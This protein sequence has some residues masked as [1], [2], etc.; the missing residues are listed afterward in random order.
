MAHK[1]KYGKGATGHLCKHY[2]RAKDGKGEYITFS[3]Q[4]IDP[5]RTHMNYNLAPDRGLSQID[6]IHQRLDQVYCLN[7][8]DVNIMVDWIVTLPA[9]VPLENSREFFEHTYDFLTARYGGFEN[10]NVI[11]A[12]VHMD[13]K[14]PHIHFAFIPVVYDIEKG[15]DKVSAK[16]VISKKDLKTFHTD[17]ERFL[18]NERGF[19]CQVINEATKDGNRSIQELKRGTAQEQL[20]EIQSEVAKTLS[21]HL[22]LKNEINNMIAEKKGLE[23]EIRGLRE[24]I[25][26]ILGI[27]E[28]Y[29]GTIDR[30]E[31]VISGLDDLCALYQT[32]E[33]KTIQQTKV[34]GQLTEQSQKISDARSQQSKNNEFIAEKRKSMEHWMS[35]VKKTRTE[36]Q[37]QSKSHK[38]RD[39]ESR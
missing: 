3:N 37:D 19:P 11:S 7:R 1:E 20:T 38:T 35:E 14:T 32:L 34:L 5:D 17:L 16:E 26:E 22:T 23:E 4:D 18:C 31:K 27:M 39:Y 24:G 21:K 15:R 25:Q 2:E 13:E 29:Q 6:F 30:Q 36:M 28:K 8:K 9:D 33:E 12:Y 10:E